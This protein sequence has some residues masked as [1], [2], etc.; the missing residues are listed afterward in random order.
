MNIEL[1]LNETE[2][3]QLAGILR[4][5]PE[6]L[7]LAL[8]PY[9]QAALTEYVRMFLGQKVFT[10]GSDMREYRLFLLIKEAFDNRIPDEQRICDLFQTTST[11]S[12]SLIRSVMSKYQYELQDAKHSTL[13]ETIEQATD[14]NG[15]WVV[16]IQSENI[17]ESLNQTLGSIDGA[18]PQVVKKKGSVASYVLLPSSYDA[19]CSFFGIRVATH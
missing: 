7:E 10:R 14:D 16:T 9:A 11:Q 18:L 8:E 19:L 3:N 12:K 6:E 1:R 4:V 17:V 13:R 15:D 5:E 2:Q